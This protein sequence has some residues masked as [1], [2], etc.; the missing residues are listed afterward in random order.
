MRSTRS[1]K[2]TTKRRRGEEVPGA[3]AT[4]RGGG[5]ARS[6]TTRAVG[7]LCSGAAERESERQ[8]PRN[9]KTVPVGGDAESSAENRNV[10]RCERRGRVASGSSSSSSE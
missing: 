2:A 6:D 10:D 3:A 7:G 8:T 1:N 9:K 4:H 5:G